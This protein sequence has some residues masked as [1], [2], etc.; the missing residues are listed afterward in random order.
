MGGRWALRAARA[1][2]GERFL[3][4]GATVVVEG[5]RI[6]GVEPAGHALPDDVPV[7]E[8]GG[9]LL[10][11]LVDSHVHLVSSGAFPGTPGS[12]EW[13][14][15]ADPAAVDAVV[16]ASLRAQAAAGVTTVRDLGDVD[17]RT[18]AHRGRESEG[19]PRVRTAGPPVTIPDGHCHFLGG[20]VDPADPRRWTG[21]SRSAS[22][23]AST[24]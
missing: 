16:T 5:D 21:R 1:F 10:P 12:L 15:T 2:D 23:A 9:T 8:V 13:A 7:T 19:L 3:T 20:V 14:G 17:Y 18:L 6:V 11:G 22:S 4:D 24:W